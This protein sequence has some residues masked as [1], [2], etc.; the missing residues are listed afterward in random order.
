MA[1]FPWRSSLDDPYATL[2]CQ[3]SGPLAGLKVLDI[4]RFMSGPFGG[5]S[6]RILARTWSKWRS[7]SKAIPCAIFPSMQPS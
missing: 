7:R 3:G 2:A 4:S 6:L 5:R 1:D